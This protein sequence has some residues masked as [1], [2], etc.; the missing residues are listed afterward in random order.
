MEWSCASQ[1]GRW[2]SPTQQPGCG[3][4]AGHRRGPTCPHARATAG[5]SPCGAG[6]QVRGAGVRQE[7]QFQSGLLYGL[8]S[9]GQK[10]H[11]L[12]SRVLLFIYLFI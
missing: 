8:V 7:L 1:L 4:G 2:G 3:V 5:V 10:P 6:L 12:Q 9:C 11:F